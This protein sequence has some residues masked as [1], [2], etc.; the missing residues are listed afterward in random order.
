M[1][2]SVVNVEMPMKDRNEFYNEQQGVKRR[3]INEEAITPKT[4]VRNRGRISRTM[5]ILLLT[6]F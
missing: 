2:E 1:Y 4:L 6:V 3:G 5:L